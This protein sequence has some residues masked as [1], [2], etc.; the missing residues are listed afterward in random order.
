MR[1]G[2]HLPVLRFADDGN[3]VGVDRLVELARTADALGFHTLAAAD[4]LLYRRP[5]LDGL[6]ALAA[7]LAHSG[8]MT[9]ATTVALPVLRGPLALA[10]ALSTLHVLSGGRVVAGLGPGASEAEYDALGVSHGQRWRRFEKSVDEIRVLVNPGGADPQPRGDGGGPAVW[11]AS[12]GSAAGLRRVARFGDGWFASAF[13]TTPE[14]FARGRETLHVELDRLGRSPG[15]FPTALTSAFCYIHESGARTEQVLR[16]VLAP[17]LGRPPDE[18]RDRVL[19]GDAD[20]VTERLLRYRDAG[21]HEV[22]LWPVH[23]EIEQLH[24]F[25]EILRTS[26]L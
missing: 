14:G 23:D 26:T 24:A 9:L 13:N 12:W 7:V 20:T 19:V 11:L 3:D 22:L 21:V 6:T 17:G 18:L 8:R 15:G 16:D 10:K 1:F 5:W 4:H 2:V 25:D